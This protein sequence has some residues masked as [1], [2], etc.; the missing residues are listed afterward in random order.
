MTPCLLSLGKEIL[1]KVVYSKG[2]EFA[3]KEENS[4]VYELIS[5]D[6]QN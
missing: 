1:P 3:P 6:R 2:K 5:T 4:F